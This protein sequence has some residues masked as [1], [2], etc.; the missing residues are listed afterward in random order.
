VGGSVPSLDNICDEFYCRIPGTST[1][2]RFIA[3][4]GTCCAAQKKCIQGQCVDAKLGECPWGEC[5]FEDQQGI[6]ESSA[7]LTCAQ[8]NSTHCYKDGVPLKC[9]HTCAKMKTLISGCPYGDRKVACSIL[10]CQTV[11]NSTYNFDCCKTCENPCTDK[12]PL[13]ISVQGPVSCNK[14]IGEMDNQYY[15]YNSSVIDNCCFTCEKTRNVTNK[16]CPWKEMSDCSTR[17]NSKPHP[18]NCTAD[19]LIKC[20]HM[21]STLSVITT[22][23]SK[24]STITTPATTSTSTKRAITSANSTTQA[25]PSAGVTQR[26]IAPCWNV[27]MCGATTNTISP[28]VLGFLGAVYICLVKWLF[29]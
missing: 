16:A 24:I 2:E 8:L 11:A 5:P 23:T 17:L 4:T 18:Y 22:T 26:K 20:C 13:N 10:G 9:C 1:C 6:V 25:A 14:F 29:G 21:C 19:E 7:N 3:A 12:V 27:I 15:C 28:S